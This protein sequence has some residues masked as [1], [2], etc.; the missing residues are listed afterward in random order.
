MSGKKLWW[1]VS[2]VIGAIV[3][4]SVATIGVATQQH[5]ADLSH[6][7]AFSVA[8]SAPVL[9]PADAENGVDN[10]ALAARLDQLVTPDLGTLHGQVT[11]TV[12]GETVWQLNPDAPLQ[13]ASST[14]ILTAAAAI[15]E[16]GLADVLTTEVV[17]GEE[18]GTV[19]IRAAGDVWLSNE[20]IT[21][22]AEDIGS[23]ENVLID[24]SIWS[25][26]LLLPGWDA[27]DV[28]GGYVAP[29]EPAM[30]YGARI[31]DTEGDVPRSH[32]PALDVASALAAE[33]GA[34]TVA[35][36]V[37][38]ADAEVVAS[39]ESPSLGARIGQMLETSDNVMAEA[40]GREVA[41]HRGDLETAS[42]AQATQATLE[43]LE[44][45]GFDTSRV[46]LSDNSGLSTL[47]LITPSL[48]DDI[49]HDAAANDTLRPMLAGLPIAGGSGTLTD[50]YQDLS[51]RGWVRAKTGTLTSTSALAGVVTAESGR[52]YSFALL[53][54]G[55]NVTAARA[56]LDQFASAIRES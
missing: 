20:Q 55:S 34:D 31:D 10:A 24:T 33:V 25:G 48:L 54:N 47:N 15:H 14:K 23:A 29:L 5:Y 17:T 53:S 56:G 49:L 40:I 27:L 45:N 13:P 9:I 39:T 22:L 51:G 43:V 11:D 18:P 1:S 16:L 3:V 30:L 50:R 44:E 46:E 8:D 19:V 7:P 32:T 35:E 52:V 26:D 21:E 42:G 28:D 12:T 38:P 2:A 4:A 37:A 6:D 36:G 41:L